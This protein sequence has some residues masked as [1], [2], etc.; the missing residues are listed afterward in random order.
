MG[1]LSNELKE[2]GLNSNNSNNQITDR[3]IFIK[4]YMNNSQT[5]RF[6]SIRNNMAMQEFK[7]SKTFKTSI[8]DCQRDGISYFQ[9]NILA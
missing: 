9:L 8:K 3:N 5:K 4:V 6:F 2:I 1:R 7:S